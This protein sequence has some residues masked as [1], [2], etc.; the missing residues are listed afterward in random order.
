ML[1]MPLSDLQLT[2]EPVPGKAILLCIPGTYCSPEVFE[3]LNEA[4]F[5][6]L[7]L[8]PVSWMTSPG[9]WDIPTLGRR[10]A[11]LIRELSDS[12][13]F[14]VGHSTGG[15]IALAAALAEPSFIRG[16]LL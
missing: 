11:E 5:P 15:A 8:L 7:Q 2:R 10:L 1:F 4:A 12:P 13:V 16:L 6:N 14:L 9:P 3:T